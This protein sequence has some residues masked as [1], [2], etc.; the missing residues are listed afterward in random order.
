MLGDGS[1]FQEHLD[2]NVTNLGERPVTINSVGW[3]VGK[4]KHR[5]YCIQTV[6]GPHTRQYPI[7]LAHGKSAD[8]MVSFLATPTW[9]KDF[10]TGFIKDLSDKSLKVQYRHL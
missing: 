3:A 1:P 2:I 8:F 9:V 6:S 4:R 7:E 10:A 5:R